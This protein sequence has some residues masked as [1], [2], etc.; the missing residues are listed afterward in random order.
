M[1]KTCGKNEE[2]KSSIFSSEIPRKGM[3][4]S[5]RLRRVNEYWKKGCETAY[6]LGA[7]MFF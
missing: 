6:N 5:P 3:N 1:G 4:C 2:M 7:N